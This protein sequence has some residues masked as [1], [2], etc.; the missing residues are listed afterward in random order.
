MKYFFL[1][2]PPKFQNVPCDKCYLT[3]TKIVEHLYETFKIEP[4]EYGT[5]PHGYADRGYKVRNIGK[6]RKIKFF[7][8]SYYPSVKVVWTGN[9][10]SWKN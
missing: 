8:K 9:K 10:D 2:F 3:V 6:Y 1:S 4:Y 5:S 7:V